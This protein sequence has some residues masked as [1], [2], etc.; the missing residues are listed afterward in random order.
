MHGW[1]PLSLLDIPLWKYE[2]LWD[3][4]TI[5]GKSGKFFQV[6]MEPSLYK[7]NWLRALE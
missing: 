5:I 6:S 3:E 2:E 7:T 4:Q 1:V